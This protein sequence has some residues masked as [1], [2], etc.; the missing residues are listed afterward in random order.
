MNIGVFV[1]WIFV[2]LVMIVLFP[3]VLSTNKALK[4][5]INLFPFEE[6]FN[7]LESRP[8]NISAK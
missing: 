1:S 8:L 6:E 3:L 5:E 7:I 4:R 2:T